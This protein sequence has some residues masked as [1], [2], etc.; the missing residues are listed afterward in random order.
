MNSRNQWEESI[1][2]WAEYLQGK[3]ADV[4]QYFATVLDGLLTEKNGIGNIREL[5][6]MD[7]SYTEE[8]VEQRRKRQAIGKRTLSGSKRNIGEDFIPED[9]V[10]SL[11]GK[12]K[13]KCI[14]NA[15]DELL[16]KIV[17]YFSNEFPDD[18]FNNI[19]EIE[20]HAKPLQV[21]GEFGFLGLS[22]FGVQNLRIEVE[23]I[24]SGE[25]LNL[26]SC[27]KLIYLMEELIC[28][29]E[30]SLK[31]RD[32]Y[33]LYIM[34]CII[35]K[36]KIDL[37]FLF[38]ADH[39]A[40]AIFRD[41][42]VA[43]NIYETLECSNLRS[44]GQLWKD[45]C[46]MLLKYPGVD[47]EFEAKYP[48]LTELYTNPKE[49]LECDVDILDYEIERSNLELFMS[50]PSVRKYFI[51]QGYALEIQKKVLGMMGTPLIEMYRQ[52]LANVVGGV[53]VEQELGVK[54]TE[55]T[56]AKIWGLSR[57]QLSNGKCIIFKN[58]NEQDRATD[59]D[60]LDTI[61]GKME[62]LSMDKIYL[63]NLVGK[64]IGQEI[65]R[66]GRVIQIMSGICV[67]PNTLEFGLLESLLKN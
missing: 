67:K 1:E 44:S 62:E 26:I 32:Y 58:W 40:E 64:P 65:E 21:R 55:P 18:E 54:L 52:A 60:V 14:Y 28:T 59:E 2:E 10:Y 23:K 36:K 42:I 63:V 53:I 56:N 51:K 50:Y 19:S 39:K 61:F 35:D 29:G 4:R 24:D 47:S 13:E 7:L 20:G 15:L 49:I 25:K 8:E 43:N 33:L 30:L 27:T 46:Q 66:N 12:G 11:I 5:N 34:E 57:H 41:R 48:I 9:K 3:S 16:L 17:A 45:L 38:Y 31:E 37:D 6:E 22:G